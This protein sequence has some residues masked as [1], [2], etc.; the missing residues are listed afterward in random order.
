MAVFID[1][2]I[3]AI[4]LIL[5]GVVIGVTVGVGS[6]LSGNT[7]AR[8]ISTAGTGLNAIVDLVSFVLGAGY[9]IYFWG[10]GATPGQRLFKLRVVDASTGAPIGFGRAAMRYIGYIISIL[11]CYVGLIWAAFDSRKQGWHDKIA[12]TVVLQG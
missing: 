6:A 5:L 11:V 7:S 8:D 3:V 10:I 1:G 12:G 2:I 4:P 9:F